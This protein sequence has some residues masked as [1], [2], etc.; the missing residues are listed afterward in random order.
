V[1]GYGA[2]FNLKNVVA[3][4]ITPATASVTSGLFSA[5]KG[6]IAAVAVGKDELTSIRVAGLRF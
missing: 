1:F 6:D 2:S 3:I 4:A 5:Y